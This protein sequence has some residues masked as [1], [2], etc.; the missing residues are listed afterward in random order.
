MSETERAEALTLRLAEM[1]AGAKI[2]LARQEE[3]ARN[4]GTRGNW[5]VI[6]VMKLDECRRQFRMVEELCRIAGI[7]QE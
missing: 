6:D 1:Y 5:D 2:R 7:L 3:R 4:V